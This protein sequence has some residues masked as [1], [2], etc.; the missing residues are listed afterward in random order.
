MDGS[1]QIYALASLSPKGRALRTYWLGGWVGLKAS[2]DASEKEKM[3]AWNQIPICWLPI[4]YRSHCTDCAITASHH[5]ILY[6][7]IIV[8]Y[9][10]SIGPVDISDMSETGFSW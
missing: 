9:R 3:P 6:M 1:G 10:S 8:N 7:Q 4:L 5:M 2:L